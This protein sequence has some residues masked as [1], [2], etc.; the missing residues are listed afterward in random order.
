MFRF[1]VSKFYI[2]VS[3]MFIS[4]AALS[5]ACVTSSSNPGCVHFEWKTSSNTDQ[6]TNAPTTSQQQWF[7]SHMFRI[8]GYAGYWDSRLS[9]F[10]NSWFYQDSSSLYNGDATSQQHPEWILHDQYGTPAFINWGC[11]N[12]TC[13]QYAPDYSNENFRQWW[14]SQASLHLSVGYKGLFIDDVNLIMNLTDGSNA[15]TPI[16]NNT[17]LPMTQQAWEKYIAD[18]MT[19]VRQAFPSIEICHNAIWFA[20]NA[21]PWT[22]PYLAQ[23]IK[24]ANYIN[25]ERGFADGGLTGDGGF[26]SIQNLFNLVDAIHQLGSNVIPEQYDFDGQFSLA[27]YFLV[28]NG[29]DLFANDSITPNNWPAVYDVNLGNALGARYT[30]NGLIRRDFANGIVLMNP[31][32]SSTVKATLPSQFVDQNGTVVS[33]V[34]LKGREGAVLTGYVVPGGPIPD[35][36]YNIINQYSGLVMDDPALSTSGGTQIIQWAMN[37]GLNQSWRFVSKGNGYYTI[38]NAFS[39]LFLDAS[40][41]NGAPLVQQTASS[42]DS[43]LWF[44]KAS[45]SN[46]SIIN[47]ASGLAIDD[48]GFSTDQG[49]KLIVWGSNGGPNQAWAIQ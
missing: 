32:G 30:W 25:F 40:G 21:N 14:I 19:E 20:G 26:W 2:V 18:F 3:S 46:W 36:T 38:Q 41:W 29:T 33:S 15:L 7:Q 11:W 28:N 37:H 49:T 24:A 42:A 27:G 4:A 45:G 1:A 23:Q 6:F 44:L 39:G 12:G 10:P 31:P 13:P 48:P 35:G 16:D 9:W 22:D 47:K 5:A 17:G 34:T 43:Q 8:M